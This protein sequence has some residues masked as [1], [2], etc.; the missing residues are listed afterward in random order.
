MLLNF[1]IHYHAQWGEQIC[2]IGH[3]WSEANPLILQ[4]T[5]GDHW[6]RSIPIPDFVNELQYRYAL[7]RNDGS[8]LYEFGKDRYVYLNGVFQEHTLKD[9]WRTSSAE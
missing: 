1:S 6:Q 5:E 9:F 7:R 3:T 8:Y 2:V 4:C